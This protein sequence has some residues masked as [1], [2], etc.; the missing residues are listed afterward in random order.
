[1]VLGLIFEL[2]FKD[3][4]ML[5]IIIAVDVVWIFVEILQHEGSAVG[6]SFRA[7]V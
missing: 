3:L 5:S 4:A 7:Y 1:M 2:R 6:R